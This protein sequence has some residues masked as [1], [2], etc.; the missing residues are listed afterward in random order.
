MPG[1]PMKWPTKVWAGRSNRASGAPTCITRPRVITTWSAK[2][3]ASTW[4][5]V[6]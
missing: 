3:R 6:T 2:V 1:E 5:W 4:S